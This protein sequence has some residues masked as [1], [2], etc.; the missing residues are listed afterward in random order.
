MT[1]RAGY[2]AA[3]GVTDWR[4]RRR[5]A[6]QPEKAARTPAAADEAALGA[7]GPGAGA[8]PPTGMTG[9]ATPRLQPG[10]AADSW[11]LLAGEVAACTRC[12]LHRSRNCTVFGVGDRQARWLI[13]GEA[14]GAEEDRRGEP[15]VGRAGKLLDSMLR[16]IGL[17]RQQVYIANILKCRPPDN[18]TPLPAEVAQCLPYLERQIALLRPSI[19]LAV[20]SVAAQNLL[21]TDAP[22]GRL[23]GRVHAF[24]SA[25]TPLVVT[26]H[27][28][29]LL[30]SPGEKRRAWEDLKFARRVAGA[31]V[32]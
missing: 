1:L 19:M 6:V 18:R 17:S 26:Y 23:R 15:F 22:V 11:E 4:Q 9:P 20:G 27:P 24:G 21:G 16:A 25:R 10:P 32:A 8:Q 14:P 31:P 28:A 5:L 3:L 7:V 29:Y 30:R 13:V 2:L 12:A